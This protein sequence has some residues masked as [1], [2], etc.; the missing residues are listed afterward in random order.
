MY[1]TQASWQPDPVE[2]PPDSE[3]DTIS[4][5]PVT[6]IP[7][8]R[9]NDP[10]HAEDRAAWSAANKKAQAMHSAGELLSGL[11]DPDWRV[12]H[13]CVDRLIARARSDPRALPALLKAAM[14]DDAWQVR[15]AVVMRL[16]DFGGDSVL[17]A[18]R[19]AATDPHP[20]VRWSATY[21]LRQLGA[22]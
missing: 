21:S 15:D 14:S 9:E 17:N 8:Y 11:G 18:L 1:D 22:K 13:A 10:R 20:E 5:G 6:G 12:R 7:V 16:C 2:L 4:I 19:A 3:P